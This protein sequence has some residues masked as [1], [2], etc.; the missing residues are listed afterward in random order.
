MCISL[1][2]ISMD[3]S[4]LTLET[5]Q[6]S[7]VAGTGRDLVP[8]ALVPYDSEMA[9]QHRLVREKVAVDTSVLTL[10]RAHEVVIQ[11]ISTP[12]RGLDPPLNPCREGSVPPAEVKGLPHQIRASEQND[13]SGRAA[14]GEAEEG[15]SMHP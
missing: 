15:P 6:R 2:R 13:R 11:A 12:A 9:V 5:K 8:Q 3:L 10:I 4:V 7:P 1:L 14:T